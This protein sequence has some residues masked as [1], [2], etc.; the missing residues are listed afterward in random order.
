MYGCRPGLGGA[1]SVGVW[2]VIDFVSHAI[3]EVNIEWPL[4][5]L[6]EVYD[7]PRGRLEGLL[8]GGSCLGVCMRPRS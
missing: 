8:M 5:M 1:K 7:V 6:E 2:Q 3:V 4:Q